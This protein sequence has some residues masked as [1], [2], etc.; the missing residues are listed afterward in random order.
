MPADR[1][2]FRP[3]SE[4]LASRW[5]RLILQAVSS[6]Q[7]PSL[8]DLSSALPIGGTAVVLEAAGVGA[9]LLFGLAP[10][11]GHFEVKARTEA[12]PTPR[13]DLSNLRPTLLKEGWRASTSKQRRSAEGL[14]LTLARTRADFERAKVL[15]G[16]DVAEAT[17]ALNDVTLCRIALSNVAAKK[18]AFGMEPE[19]ID[20]FV[21]DLVH[22]SQQIWPVKAVI[23]QG[24][25][26]VVTQGAALSELP[27]AV[28]LPYPN[29]V[30][31]EGENE[32]DLT[33]DWVVT[34]HSLQDMLPRLRKQLQEYPCE[35]QETQRDAALE[36]LDAL[37]HA[38][39]DE[40]AKARRAPLLTAVVEQLEAFP[41]TSMLHRI[42]YFRQL[43]ALDEH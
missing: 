3:L 31:L 5:D 38:L 13:G 6:S 11:R 9:Q 23:G 19:Q 28:T 41:A 43:I 39:A 16:W 4:S 27:R 1:L 30:M 34:G 32:K 20:A 25:H 36:A 12:D 15:M 40:A 29:G 21:G 8:D 2:P 7:L 24:I 26:Q 42:D 33:E 14:A 18:G 17:R 35:G 37:A 22:E 10:D